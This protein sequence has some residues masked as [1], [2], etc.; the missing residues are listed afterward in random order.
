M[1]KS[2][3]PSSSPEPQNDYFDHIAFH[4]NDHSRNYKTIIKIIWACSFIFQL[5]LEICIATRT[6]KLLL[7]LFSCWL[8]NIDYYR[9]YLAI[10]VTIIWNKN[11]RIFYFDSVLKTNISRIPV[12]PR[13][14]LF[15]YISV[16]DT[17]EIFGENE[18]DFS[19][20]HCICSVSIGKFSI[21][22]MF[23]FS[24]EVKN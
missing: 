18:V 13:K 17:T 3:S 8:Y 15:V 12:A 16:C 1:V 19:G 10:T 2:Y 4:I 9:T 6:H 7:L 14:H 24:I 22:Y 11:L 20:L 5:L 21:V 23:F